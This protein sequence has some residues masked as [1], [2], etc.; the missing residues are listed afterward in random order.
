MRPPSVDALARSRA[1]SHLPHPLLVEAA[2]SAIA[3]GA[4]EQF[5]AYVERVE[6]RLLSR[7]INATGVLLHTNMGRAPLATNRNAGYTNLELDLDT[8]AR[9]S[10]QERAGL[11]LAKACG[12][13]AAI[14][15]NNCASAVMLG[16]AA[17]AKGSG[18]PVSRGEL[19]EI[20]GGFRVPEVLEQSGC[21]LVE[22]GT[23]N[24]T[25]LADFERAIAENQDIA[26]VLKVHPSNYRIEGFQQS[27]G[28][29]ALSTLGVPLI[30]DLGSGL[31][32]EACPWLE[33]GRPGWLLDEP[34][35]RQ[36]LDQ[37][38]DLVMFSG[39]KLLGG[40]QSGII[41]GR[42]EMVE[43]CA[44]HPLM[45][46]FRPGDLV[47][48]ALQDVALAYL[49]RDGDAIPFWAMATIPQPVLSRRAEAI[50][51]ASGIGMVVDSEAT[52]GGGSLP[53]ATIA[54]AAIEIAGDHSTELRDHTT[55]I[56]ARVHE[57]RTLLDLRT[58][59]PADDAI[60]TSA[61][62]ASRLEGLA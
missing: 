18:V 60:I 5:D 54:S 12:A 44:R 28:V 37:G 48:G 42:A 40:P 4:H 43:R 32:D 52:P 15:V 61:L 46:T 53:T 20:G 7:V 36:T 3:D 10:R 45:R 33:G 13:E 51:A 16:L 27:V 25:R 21:R 35:V 58:I 55:P 47:I 8:G 56:I 23:T 50:V 14:V 22:V 49:R 57:G 41:A 2:R 31:L 34:A 62:A 29:K 19:V 1:D 59:D 24:R 39:D 9:G 26:A 6:R 17:V 38:A 30:V 11:L